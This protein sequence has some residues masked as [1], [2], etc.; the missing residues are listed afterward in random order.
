[1]VHHSEA[2]RRHPGF[3]PIV[4]NRGRKELCEPDPE[5]NVKGADDGRGG[6]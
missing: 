3:G 2:V 6:L 5:A 4:H 1:M